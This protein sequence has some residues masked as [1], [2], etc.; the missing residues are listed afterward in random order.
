M[1]IRKLDDGKWWIVGVPDDCKLPEL[2][3]VGPYENRWDAEDALESQEKYDNWK[4][5]EISCDSP[6][7]RKRR[8][9]HERDD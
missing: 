2:P 9:K 1:N 5:H 7:A 4:P 3:G 8:A 6:L